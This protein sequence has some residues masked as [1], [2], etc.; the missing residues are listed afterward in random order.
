M[1]LQPIDCDLKLQLIELVSVELPPTDM[2]LVSIYML[3]SSPNCYMKLLPINIEL[4]SVD[5]NT[6]LLPIDMLL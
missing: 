4:V 2:E 5:I 1:K 3:L 6:E